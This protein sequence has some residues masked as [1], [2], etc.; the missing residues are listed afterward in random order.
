MKELKN[1]AVLKRLGLINCH[2]IWAESQFSMK[3]IVDIANQM[4]LERL[5]GA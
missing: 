4:V 3:G 5:K 1:L 2:S